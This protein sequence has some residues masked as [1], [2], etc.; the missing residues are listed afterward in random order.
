MKFG[1]SA[2]SIAGVQ[3]ECD[4]GV[5]FTSNLM[6]DKHISNIVRRANILIDI[7][8]RTFSYVVANC[9]DQSMFRTLY[10]T[11]ICP[12]LDYASVYSMESLSAWTY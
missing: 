4:L 1:D 5:T 11:L 7:I 9:L 6:F 8:K 12:H 3:A 2:A 10:T